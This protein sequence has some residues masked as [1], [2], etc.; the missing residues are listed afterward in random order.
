MR[1]EHNRALRLD[2][3]V[4]VRRFGTSKQC[5]IFFNTQALGVRLDQ[6]EISLRFV[7]VGNIRRGEIA[8]PRTPNGHTLSVPNTI[9]IASVVASNDGAFPRAPPSSTL[10]L[11][12]GFANIRTTWACSSACPTTCLCSAV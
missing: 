1:V 3:R 4:F 2:R 11:V 10:L 7:K 8:P 5:C 6:F 9:N 12:Q